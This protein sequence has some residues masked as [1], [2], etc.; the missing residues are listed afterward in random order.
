MPL[1]MPL[2][3][4][5]LSVGQTR[6]EIVSAA[7]GGATAP[8][9]RDGL[10]SCGS[11]GARADLALLVQT[12][13]IHADAAFGRELSGGGGMLG[14]GQVGLGSSGRLCEAARVL[15]ASVATERASRSTSEPEAKRRYW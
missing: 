15:E 6:H 8:L 3:T 10:I 9:S 13:A 2:D 14:G 11:S 4:Q 12:H 1:S 5:L 7:D